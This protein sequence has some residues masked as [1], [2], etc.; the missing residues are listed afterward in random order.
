MP[1][2]W[3][4]VNQTVLDRLRLRDTIARRES[5]DMSDQ[6]SQERSQREEADRIAQRTSV[7]EVVGVAGVEPCVIKE[8]VGL[9]HICERLGEAPGVHT[10][11]VVDNAGRLAGI[12]PV[13]LLLNEL[14]LRVAPEEFLTDLREMEGV[15]EFGKLS[16]ARS[17]R[18][19][20]EP[21]VY[22][23]MDDSVREAFSRMHEQRL[24]GLPIVDKDMRVVGY[25][26]RLHLIQIWLQ[27]HRREEG[28]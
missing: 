12:I 9:L 16:R 14:F 10:I 13:R 22:V 15:E 4:G 6:S 28:V 8:D 25:L 23:T 20:M 17:A 27:K 11:A 2:G 21:A 24:E 5:S 7:R 19:L 18:D 3:K 1:E 26:D